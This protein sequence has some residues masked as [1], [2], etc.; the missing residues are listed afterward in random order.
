V[1][2]APTLP[3]GL[4]YAFYSK[5][6]IVVQEACRD[7]LLQQRLLWQ[8]HQRKQRQRTGVVVR[9]CSRYNSR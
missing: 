7:L 4:C 1:E 5:Y 2:R 6:A 3:H 8:P 9:A